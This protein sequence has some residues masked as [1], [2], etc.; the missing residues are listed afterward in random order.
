MAIY[1][2]NPLK[3][4]RWADLV[5]TQTSASIFH[6]PGWLEALR[7]TYG[8]E[9]VVFTT[10]PPQAQ[11]TNGIVF[12]RISSWL[13]GRRMVS[14]PFADHCEPLSE[15]AED[16]REIFGFLRQ[17]LK[18]ENWKYI[19]IRPRTS[20]LL[21][22]ISSKEKG[23]SFCFHLL[24]LHPSL[25]T[26]F[27]G[28]QKSSIQRMIRRAEREGL[29]CENGRSEALLGKF[30]RLML[31]T[32]RRHKLPPQPISWFRNLIACLGDRLNIRVTSKN[33]E[34][35]AGILTLSHR[36]TLVY[37]YGCSDARYH[38]WGSVPFLLWNAIR[39]AKESGLQEFDLGRSDLGNSGLIHFK[40]R[41]GAK[42]SLLEYVRFS[43][44]GFAHGS[45]DRGLQVAKHVFAC[46]PDGLLTTAG[47]LL[48]RHI[49]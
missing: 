48:Y 12:C 33:G 15:R 20:G 17:T 10:S 9:P 22:E 16:S 11:L 21:L 30:Y 7:L 1:A 23:D 19:E 45:E 42:A 34:A 14:L 8:Y 2:I 4:P 39:E 47:K 41:W 37:K 36:S 29:S 43:A 46:L 18:A 35:I 25:D 49:G 5:Q 40:D 27:G 26:L 28:L 31:K 32:R 6:T 44:P 3:D 13:T 38:H 24:D